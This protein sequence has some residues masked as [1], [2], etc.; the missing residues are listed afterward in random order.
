MLRSPEGVQCG[1]PAGQ[2]IHLP[3][4]AQ[5]RAGLAAPG[6]SQVACFLAQPEAA[7]YPR[8][9]KW[10]YSLE[11]MIPGLDGGQRA[12]WSPD[13]RFPIGHA[14]KIYEYLQTVLGYALGLLAFAGFSGL[15]KTR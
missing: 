13:T 9:N 5:V 1:L 10:I 14:G 15:V 7:A 12:Y 8:F 4:I 6:Q 11:T 3:S 2:E